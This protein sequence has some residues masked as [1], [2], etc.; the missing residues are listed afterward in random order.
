[1]YPLGKERAVRAR[2]AA[3]ANWSSAFAGFGLSRLIIP[4]RESA[5]A[6]PGTNGSEA[7]PS[8]SALL[9]LLGDPRTPSGMGRWAQ[10]DPRV[11]ALFKSWLAKASL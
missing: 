1:M 10:V 6:S 3:A 4:V 9:G 2:C 5:T 8:S 11:V 7:A